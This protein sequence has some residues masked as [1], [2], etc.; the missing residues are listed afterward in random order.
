[1]EADGYTGP[2]E[3]LVRVEEAPVW[4]DDLKGDQESCLHAVVRGQCH[5]ELEDLQ[6]SR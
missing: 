1:M 2:E 5:E 6:T 3:V 4:E